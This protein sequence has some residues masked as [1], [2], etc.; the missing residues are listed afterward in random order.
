MSN[1]RFSPTRFEKRAGARLQFADKLLLK[2][3]LGL[4]SESPGIRGLLFH[5][6][7]QDPKEIFRAEILP[8]QGLTLEGYREF[9]E[10]LLNKDYYFL[11]YSDLLRP[12]SKQKKY[13]YVTFDDGYFNNTRILP[14]IEELNIPIHIFV[15]TSNI[16]EKKKYWWD[17]IYQKGNPNQGLDKRIR[18]EIASA[19]LRSYE[20]IERDLLERYGDQAFD[21]LS[22]LDRPLSSAELRELSAN[23]LVTIGNHMHHHKIVPRLSRSEFAEE[24]NTCS[25]LI[26]EI[27]GNEPAGFAFP[28]GDFQDPDLIALEQFCI[29]HVFTC[30][31]KIVNTE[32]LGIRDRLKI[33]GRYGVSCRSDIEWTALSIMAGFSVL[34]WAQILTK[35]SMHSKK[36]WL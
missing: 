25:Q 14:L 4:F 35:L 1:K 26:C 29:N 17:V 3:F 19:K 9:F 12:L 7:Y 23:S 13:L 15:N 2:S 24:V 10:Y 22:D 18:K 27:T 8:Y 32:T 5:T 34:R 6:V 33:M 36:P 16:V 20:D 28:N 11:S 31:P 30:D 21:P